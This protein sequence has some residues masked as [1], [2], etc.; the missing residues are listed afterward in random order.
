MHSNARRFSSRAAL[1]AAAGEFVHGGPG[2]GG[3]IFRA[4]TSVFV[5]GLDVGRLTLLLVRVT[6]FIALRHGG[7]G[8][9]RVI[10]VV[11]VLGYKG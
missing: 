3:G 5:T 4:K 2:A 6:G 8:W 1:F 7:G 11:L 10:R 9:F